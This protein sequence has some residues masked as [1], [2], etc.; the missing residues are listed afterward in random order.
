LDAIGTFAFTSKEFF[1]GMREGRERERV[2]G[3]WREREHR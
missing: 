1:G 3:R 2:K